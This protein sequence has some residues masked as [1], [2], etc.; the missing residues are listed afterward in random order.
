[1]RIDS[2]S[3]LS[4][5]PLIAPQSRNVPDVPP[6]RRRAARILAR[7]PRR[8][9]GRASTSAPAAP[10]VRPPRT[11]MMA[12]AGA[13]G[14]LACVVLGSAACPPHLVAQT[15]TPGAPVA[16]SPKALPRIATIDP[17][18]QSYNVEMAEVTGGNFWKPYTR[19]SIATLMARAS[20]A[21]GPSAF[22]GQV[23]QDTTMF[24]YRPPLDL[25]NSRLRRMAAALGPAYVRVSGSWANSI[26]FHDAATPA[27]EKAPS[28]FEG[29][30]T[31]AQW[32]GVLDFARAANARLMTSFAIS[33]GVRD[34]SGTW[35]PVQAHKLVRYTN[36]LGGRIA[37]AEFFNEPDMPE[38]AGAPK[39]YD[40]AQYARDHAAFVRFAR[41]EAPGMR[42]VGPSSVGEGALLQGLEGRMPG[43]MSTRAMFS[44]TP[45]PQVDVF[46][47]HHYPA[48]SIRCGMLSPPDTALSEEFLSRTDREYEFYVTGIRDQALPNRPPVWI[49]ETA[50]AACGGNPWA[51]TFLDTFRYTDQMGRLARRGVEVIYHNT[52]TAS[53]Y[54]LLDQNTFQPRPN[55]W[56]AL[57][58]HRLMGTTVLDAG[59]F[60]PGLHLYA[61]CLRGHPGGVTLLAIDNSRTEASSIDLATAADRYTLSAPELESPQAL[62]NG[63][64]LGLGASDALPELR[65]ERVA[66]GRVTLAPATITYLAVPAADNPAC[67]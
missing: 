32:R 61:H 9:G 41:A 57:L 24:Q 63:R 50:D 16:I 67:R 11:S 42:V 55:Y 22:S 49:T 23:G 48:G 5:S 10:A 30:L 3:P 19:E 14:L 59:P 28:G 4:A 54:G 56:A 38:Y 17:R 15:P 58:W 29:V 34:S 62:L 64:E 47:Y 8:S 36:T 51:A 7:D 60:R 12:S 66:A 53:D 46:S 2:A 52:L 6:A 1:M 33:Q 37:A 20:A 39:G 21:G 18:F 27:P 25:T 45:R 44:A 26:Y 40:A 43:F 31:R 13:L 65:G 35:T